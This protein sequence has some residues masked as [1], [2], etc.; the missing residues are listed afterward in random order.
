MPKQLP[1]E[2]WALPILGVE[3]RVEREV[4]VE[5]NI[6]AV[7]LAVFVLLFTRMTFVSQYHPENMF[8]NSAPDLTS[9]AGCVEACIFTTPVQNI[10]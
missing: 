7:K 6:S 1:P 3:E 4:N 9:Q 8:A 10:Y 2:S 5:I